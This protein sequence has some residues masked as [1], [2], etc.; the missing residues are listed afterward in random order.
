[1]PEKRLMSVPPDFPLWRRALA[2]VI[3]IT[4]VLLVC[5]AT[6]A[7]AVWR[8]W[9]LPVG[10]VGGLGCGVLGCA[11]VAQRIVCGRCGRSIV[12]V[13]WRPRNCPIRSCCRCGAALF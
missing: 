3:L 9:A 8:S 4:G 6:V 13:G 1:M 7:E 12:C 2:L 10:I 11:L 5:A